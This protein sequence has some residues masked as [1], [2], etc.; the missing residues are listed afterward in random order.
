MRMFSLLAA[1]AAASAATALIALTAASV[2]ATAAPTASTAGYLSCTPSV[3]KPYKLGKTTAISVGNVTCNTPADVIYVETI[4]T[5][6]YG[7]RSV[8]SQT[9]YNTTFCSVRA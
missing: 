4:L 3:G 9:C 2:P 8:G 1:R 7:G 5:S 6:S